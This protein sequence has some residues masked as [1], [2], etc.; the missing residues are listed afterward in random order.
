MSDSLKQAELNQIKNLE[1]KS[2]KK[3]EEWLQIVR[4][5]GLTKH[6]DVLELLKSQYG[7]GHGYANLVAHKAKGSDARSVDN[8]DDLITEQYKG[9]EELKKWYDQLM[10]KITLFGPDVELAPKKAYVSLRRKKQF[11]ILQPSTKTRLDIGL[12]MK[13]VDASGSLES[14]GSW[15]AMCTHR[16]KVEEASAITPQVINWI[17]Q[18]YDQAG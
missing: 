11:A 5:S 2:G 1:E 12:N 18:A 6:S 16:I 7:M 10:E 9:K 8:Q 14:S 4:A 3:F 13:G 17:K 15:N